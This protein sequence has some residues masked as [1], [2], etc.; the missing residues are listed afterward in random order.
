MAL[1]DYRLAGIYLEIDTYLTT[2][3]SRRSTYMLSACLRLI[4]WRVE[5]NLSW[6]IFLL[7]KPLSPK[8]YSYPIGHRKFACPPRRSRGQGFILFP[9]CLDPNSLG[10]WW[11]AA[12][13][14]EVGNIDWRINALPLLSYFIG[15]RVK[16]APQV[17]LTASNQV[18]LCCD[19]QSQL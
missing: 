11:R 19:A 1:Y 5:W 7:D 4:L 12:N 2:H 9:K 13:N 18:V 15:S 3:D 14:Q 16:Q 17:R 6:D 10:W 8:I